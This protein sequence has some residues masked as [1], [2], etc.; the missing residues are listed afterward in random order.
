[1]YRGIPR[2]TGVAAVLALVACGG[3]GKVEEDTGCSGS[4]LTL[5]P[6]SARVTAGGAGVSFGAG[7]PDCTATA[8]WV[9][10]G[11]GSLDRS[12]GVPVVYTPPAS[13][14]A[15]TPATL[16]A[17]MGVLTASAAITIDPAILVVTG[18]VVAASGAPIAG[19]TVRAGASSATTDATGT[20]TLSGVSPPYEI[21]ATAPGGLLTSHY[22]ELRRMDPTLVIFDLDPGFP[23][24]GLATGTLSGAAGFPSPAGHEAGVSF[25]SEQGAGGCAVQ[26]GSS[27]YLLGAGWSGGPTVT[28]ELHA[29]QWQVD[30]S[31]KVVAYDGYGSRAGVTVADRSPATAGQDIALAAIPTR[32]V[33]GTILN[34]PGAAMTLFAVVGNGAR[35]RVVPPPSDPSPFA[36][37]F[38]ST[39]SIPTPGIPGATVDVVARKDYVGWGYMEVHRHGLAPDAGSVA[40][41]FA[42]LPLQ[43]APASGA[44]VGPGATFT[45]YAM[46]DH[47][48]YVVSFRGSPGIPGYDVFTTHASLT[49]PVG[50]PFPRG[51][52]YTW[53]VRGSSAFS[54]LDDAAGPGGFLAPAPA[55]RIARS[56]DSPFTTAP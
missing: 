13:V 32:A 14:A 49:V 53:F 15:V 28:G 19:A 5:T 7:A 29:L 51:A 18:R 55:Y 11:P 33:S 6:P 2:T 46:P 30:A 36:P 44:T 34:P 26:A 38:S 25:K 54:T 9:L 17:T 16:T 42:D 27:T 50:F 1:M 21:V 22:L 20:F 41:E 4:V 3:G 24:S 48:V 47:P 10:S 8:T 31:G 40:L 23:R 45:W 39:F 56:P 35:I 43:I 37:G 12:Q 52:A